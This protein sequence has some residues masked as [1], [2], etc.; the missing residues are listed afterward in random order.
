MNPNKI[1]TSKWKQAF[2]QQQHNVHSFK[3]GR[4]RR[5][6]AFN[7]LHG[8]A[9]EN[10]QKIWSIYR[11]AF[12]IRGEG[13]FTD[14]QGLTYPLKPGTFFQHIPNS[15]HHV[16]RRN[17]KRW[18]TL[19]LGLDAPTFHTL[20]AIGSIRITPPTYPLNAPQTLL[21]LFIELKKS[22]RSDGFKDFSHIFQQIHSLLIAIR[23][24]S[25]SISQPSAFNLIEE[26][27]RRLRTNL[28]TPMSWPAFCQDLGVSYPLFRK[29]FKEATGLA[30]YA[31]RLQA[32]LDTAAQLLR[33]EELTLEQIADETG[34]SDSFALSKQFKH[35]TGMPP[36]IYRR[37]QQGKQTP[38]TPLTKQKNQAS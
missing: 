8:A 17:P 27:K 13:T 28:H 10:R 22:L 24:Q 37:A 36:S 35:K 33:D 4:H 30:P 29:Q 6:L 19:S 31:Y 26:S 18:L 25:E 16:R 12:I 38:A 34:F 14:S 15:Y 23:N 5:E 7:I 1:L 32:K 9:L 3:H 20:A 21:P 11:G 2:P